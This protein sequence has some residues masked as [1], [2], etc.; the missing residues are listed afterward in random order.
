[1]ERFAAEEQEI[2]LEQGA[3]EP[4]IGD[5]EYGEPERAVAAQMARAGGDFGE[6]IPAERLVDP[7]AGTRGMRRLAAK[8]TTAMASMATPSLHRWLVHAVK[9]NEPMDVPT[10]MATKV[11][12]SSSALPRERSRPGS[13]S[14]T[15]PYLAGLNTAECRAIRK[16]T[17]SIHSMLVVKKWR[18]PRHGE[19][20]KDLD[21]DEYFAFADGVGEM[22]GIAGEEQERDDKDGAGE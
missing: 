1:M 17:N 13:I 18:D 14:G 12:I 4:E 10:T 5:A 8:P 19:D 16:S 3:E 21:A 22:A 15:M 9:R 11:V 20:L 2:H 7:A 6:G